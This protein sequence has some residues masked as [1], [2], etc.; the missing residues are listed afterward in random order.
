MTEK[1]AAVQANGGTR[2]QREKRAAILEAGLTVF[3]EAGFRGA[4]LD[5]IA[6]EAGLSKPNLLYYF[7]SKEAIYEAL[8]QELLETW[9]DPLK[10]LNPSGDPVGELLSYVMRKLEMARDFPR[11]SRLFANEILA[12][13]PAMLP[14]LEGELRTLVDHTAAVIDGWVAE[15]RLAKIDA[16]HLLF[17][18]WAQTQH[19]ADFDTQVRAV[20]GK[21]DFD[22]AAAHL[23]LLFRRVLT[24]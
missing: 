24:P 19:Y 6:S 7:P 20:M 17:S 22:G 5:R 15:G 8:L 14:V 1:T 2:I 21:A 13:A 23:D 16:R 12:G 9:L 4:T 18:I 10:A 11:E 3:A